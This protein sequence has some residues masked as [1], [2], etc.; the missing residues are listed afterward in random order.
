MTLLDTDV[1]VDILRNHP[2]AVA[3]LQSLRAVPLGLPGLVVM[4]LL[5]GCQN[6]T[7][8]QRIEQFCR[9]YML[10]WPTHSDCDRALQDFA[11]FHLSHN[12]GLL[13]ALIAHTA[14]GLSE[15]LATFNVKH[16][17]VVAALNTIQ[18]Y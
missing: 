13:D 4:E 15:P 3:W 7:E 17:G 1:A 5:Q 18:P 11:A 9:P 12:L 8:Q 16:Y 6:K 10:H 14:V 2:P